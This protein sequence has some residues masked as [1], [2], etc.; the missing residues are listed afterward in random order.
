MAVGNQACDQVDQEFDGATMARMLDLIDVFELIRDSF[1]DSSF[2]EQEF[3][4]P[5]E[6]A[7]VHLC[8]QLGDEVQ[9]VGH[10]QLLSERLGE[11]AFVAKEFAHQAFRQ[12][13][14]GMP[15]IE[16]ARGEAKGQELALIVDNQVQLEAVKP[17]NRGFATSGSSGKDAVLVDT[18]V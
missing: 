9:A 14:N 16:V 5:V 10:Q 3:V 11:I 18:S 13:G 8:A 12:L 4:R 7:V 1:D 2:A 15:I 17:A 6:Q